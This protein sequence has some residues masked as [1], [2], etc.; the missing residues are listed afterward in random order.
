MTD[1][2]SIFHI[3]HLNVTFA[4]VLNSGIIKCEPTN[5]QRQTGSMRSG[6]TKRGYMGLKTSFFQC[7]TTVSK[8]LRS[9]SVL[10]FFYAKHMRSKNGPFQEHLA[11][12]CQPTPHNRVHVFVSIFNRIISI[13]CIACI[14]HVHMQ[15]KLLYTRSVDGGCSS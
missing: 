5:Q 8:L 3:K 11:P 12:L 1:I 2:L 10:T 6:L 14:Y 4:G 9:K 13:I 7:A 15:Y